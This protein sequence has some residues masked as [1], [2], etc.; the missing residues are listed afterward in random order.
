MAQGQTDFRYVGDSL[1]NQQAKNGNSSERDL[2][3]R[4]AYGRYY[5][6]SFHLIREALIE[7]DKKWN[8]PSHASVPN[9]L[10]GTVQKQIFMKINN[11]R[12]RNLL[13]EKDAVLL[14]LGVEARI[15]NLSSLMT[16]AVAVRTIADYDLNIKVYNLDNMPELDG[17]TIEI[18]S[19]W[20]ETVEA[21]LKELWK[22]CQKIALV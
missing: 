15:N 13:K 2:L 7:I 1:R 5:Y 9:M 10:R 6:A 11:F 20:P 17:I 3:L 22:I 8:C 19:K 21:N 12:K 4:A 16:D 18:A 14:K